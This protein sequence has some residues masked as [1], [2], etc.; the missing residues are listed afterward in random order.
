MKIQLTPLEIQAHADKVERAFERE[1][2]PT[3]PQHNIGHDYIVTEEELL[4]AVH[5]AV[6]IACGGDQV[7]QEFDLL[8]EANAAL[9]GAEGGEELPP[10]AL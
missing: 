7:G 10:R 5:M 1:C 4:T 2:L 9:D 3:L 8:M 6:G